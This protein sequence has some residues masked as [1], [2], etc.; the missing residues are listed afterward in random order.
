M[1]KIIHSASS[2]RKKIAHL[3][4]GANSQMK[5]SQINFSKDHNPKRGC[6]LNKANFLKLNQYNLIE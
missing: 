3:E 6:K 4:L 2:Q 5:Q 1:I